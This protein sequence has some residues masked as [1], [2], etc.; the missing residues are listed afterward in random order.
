MPVGVGGIAKPTRSWKKSRRIMGGIFSGSELEC[1]PFT[2]R[3]GTN[4]GVG[5]EYFSI[6]NQQFPVGAIGRTTRDAV[7][8]KDLKLLLRDP[9]GYLFEV[10]LNAKMDGFHPFLN[11][12]AHFPSLRHRPDGYPRCAGFRSQSAGHGILVSP[13][14]RLGVNRR[15]FGLILSS[16]LT[17]WD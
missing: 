8:A 4:A 16:A 3:G 2:T 7:V 13:K 5:R 14:A 11:I 9:S 6:L 10:L 12:R 15:A 17:C 1:L